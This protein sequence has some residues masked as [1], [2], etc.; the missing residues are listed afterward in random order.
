MRRSF[1]YVLIASVAVSALLGIMALFSSNLG[2]TEIKVLLST[3]CV[4][5]ASILSLACAAAWEKNRAR[6]FAGPGVGAAAVGFGLFFIGIWGEVRGEVVWKLGATG[7][8]AGC[9]CA[10]AALLL[11]VRLATTHRWVQAA[12]IGCTAL[13]S[14]V[15]LVVILGSNSPSDAWRAIGVF[16]ILGTA[17][18]IL[19]AVF[20]RMA[21]AAE[22]EEPR[23][24]RCPHCGEALPD[25]FRSASWR[26]TA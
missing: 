13:L 15:L 2:E 5:G 21:P 19:T 7:V 1:L 17:G 23:A 20:R 4:A 25:G 24:L 8:I 10:H 6:A 26:G 12:T 14:V 9:F 3:L 11:L 18:T 16:A 22:D